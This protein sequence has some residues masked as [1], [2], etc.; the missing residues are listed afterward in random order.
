VRKSTAS[1]IG[2]TVPASG[3][4]VSRQS[5]VQVETLLKQAQLGG[6]RGEA[7]PLQ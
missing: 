3:Y 7:A 2:P 6:L 4:S 1:S 5:A